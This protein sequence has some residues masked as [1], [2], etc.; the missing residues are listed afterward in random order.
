MNFCY[1]NV[2]LIF[3]IYLQLHN[4]VLLLRDC[5]IKVLHNVTDKTVILS[6]VKYEILTAADSR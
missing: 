2:K 4:F 1:I 3:A 5:R 6:A